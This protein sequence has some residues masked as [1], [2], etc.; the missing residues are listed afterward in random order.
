MLAD[1]NYESS[2]CFSSYWVVVVKH[3]HLGYGDLKSAVSQGNIKLIEL[4]FNMLIKM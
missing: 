4:I 2:S 1:T 3:S